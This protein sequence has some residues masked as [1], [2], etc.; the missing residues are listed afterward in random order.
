MTTRSFK[1]YQPNLSK[2][3]YIDPAAI[4]IGRVSLADDCSVWPTSVI[5]GDVNQIT[6]GERSNVQDGS[7][8]HVNH[9][10][11]YYGGGST[12]NIGSDV[13]IGHKVMIHGAHIGNRCL[14]GMGTIILDG[15]KLNDEALLAAGSLVPMNK[16]LEGGYL[17]MGSPVK[18]IRPLN[19]KERELFCYSATHY[20][21]LK[22]EYLLK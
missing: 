17:W 6:I 1:E 22:N 9:E 7:I 16:E 3:V 13:T 10:S 21:G 12:V 15:A 18:K 14:I 4:V 19:D 8:I 5:R 11:E 20:V 2:N